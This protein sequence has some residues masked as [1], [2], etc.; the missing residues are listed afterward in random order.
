MIYE[1]SHVREE[2][3]YGPV[4]RQHVYALGCN[5]D[6]VAKITCYSL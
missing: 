1:L 4:A 6:H 2:P 5:N 3:C